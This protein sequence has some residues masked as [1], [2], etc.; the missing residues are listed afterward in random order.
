MPRNLTTAMQAHIQQDYVTLACCWRIDLA[1]SGGSFGFTSHTR[2]LV[3]DGLI[4]TSTVGITP[5]TVTQE[6]G[7]SIDNMEVLAVVD[8]VTITEEDLLTGRYDYARIT[9]FLTNWQDPAGSG[10]IILMKGTIGEVNLQNGEFKTEAR[11]LLQAATQEILD[12][13][14]PMCRYKLGDAGCTIN[15]AGTSAD[16][17]ALTQTH[18]V[19]TVTNRKQFTVSS[20]DGYTNFFQ[21]G[22]VKFTS[23]ANNG[24][25]M[26]IKANV[27]A[28][29]T[30]QEDM[31]HD[32]A[33]GDAV[34]LTAGCDWLISTCSTRFNNVV[35][36]GGEPY[37]PGVDTVLQIPD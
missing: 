36:F 28:L 23:G 20:I 30:L 6:S 5:S 11:S 19:A 31:P 15:L 16:G 14:S 4:Y 3:I 1:D 21:Y 24:Q 18:T 9:V 25:S 37:V 7:T 10:K 34:T 29:F 35:N 32:I 8:G 27:G 33:V 26:E 17:H 22:T 12:L 13:T 2:P